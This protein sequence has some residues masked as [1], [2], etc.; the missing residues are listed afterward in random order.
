MIMTATMC[1]LFAL[2]YLP[3]QCLCNVGMFTALFAQKVWLNLISSMVGRVPF[4][5]HPFLET[6]SSHGSCLKLKMKLRKIQVI[7]KFIVGSTKDDKGGGKYFK[8]V[9]H[10]SFLYSYLHLLFFCEIRKFD[11]RNNEEIEKYFKEGKERIE[12]LICGHLYVIDF[13][14]MQ[15]YRKDW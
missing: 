5:G 14:N 4:A 8:I 6:F 3:Y 7:Q 2:K 9:V 12:L 13:T 15:Q 11:Q 10:Q 1:V